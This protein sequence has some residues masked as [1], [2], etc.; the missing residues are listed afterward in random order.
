[1]KKILFYIT[2]ALAI[3]LPNSFC[4]QG[5]TLA[6]GFEA[7]QHNYGFN[8]KQSDNNLIFDLCLEDLSEDDDSTDSERKKASS[9]QLSLNNTFLVAQNYSKNVLNKVFAAHLFFPS[10]TAL[11]I[12]LC[13]FRL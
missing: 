11:F 2:I 7:A 1:M 9:A 4:A 8:T 6:F 12:F 5:A 10:K 3:L 13:V